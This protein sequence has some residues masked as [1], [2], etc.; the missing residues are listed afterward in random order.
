MKG[1]FQFALVCLTL[2][3]ASVVFAQQS[4]LNK[5]RQDFEH[6]NNDTVRVNSA[7]QLFGRYIYAKVD[8]AIFY[9]R[10]IISIGDRMGADDHI[11]T[12]NNYLGIAY[13]VKGDFDSAANYMQRVLEIHQVNQDSINVAYSLN[14]IGM[15]YLYAGD[16]LKAAQA[17]IQ[18]VQF[19]E[20]LI[21]SGSSSQE[22]DLA[23]TLM[24]IGIAYQSQQDTLQAKTYYFNAIEE[25]DKVGNQAITARSKTSLGNLLS[26]EDKFEEALVLFLEAEPVFVEENDVFALGKLYNNTA[27]VYAGLE[28]GDQVISYAN[29]AIAQN[30]LVGNR[31]SEGL[32]YVYLGLGYIKINQLRKAIQTSNTALSIGEELE[33]NS[34]LHGALKNL[35]EA[36]SALGAYKTAYDYSLRYNKIDNKIYAIER[37]EQMERLSAKYEADKREIE[38]DKL[39]QEAQLSDLELEKANA[40]RNLLILLLVS[41]IL[42]MV[43]IVYFYQKIAIN[44]K[45]LREKNE[46]LQKLNKT[47]DR[48]F[49]IVSHDLRG[50]INSFKG[51]G[52]LL[53]RLLAKK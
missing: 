30:K 36:H 16:Y 37:A 2:C 52:R 32:S 44:R 43:L 28:Q 46:E 17:L 9:A 10:Q 8:S 19:K 33:D 1:R 3:F 11:L 7:K 31:Q 13:S 12:G 25:A 15:N 4:D 26:S 39:N 14:N 21:V 50:H 38:I 40:N 49:T 22:V 18:A 23:S 6:S 41:A 35:Y 5:L 29:K 24:N 53:S 45:L 42:I 47:K 51:T 27:L 34:I 20:A 48:F